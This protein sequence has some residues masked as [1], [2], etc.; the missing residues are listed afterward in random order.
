MNWIREHK[1]RIIFTVAII[2]LVAMM[3]FSLMN[4]GKVPGI[5]KVTQAAT[6]A[7]ETP[8]ATA[9]TEVS[10]FFY[11]LTHFRSIQKE[12]Y[13]LKNEIG[14]LQ[15]E[16]NNAK[17]TS[18][19]YEEFKNIANQLN[20]S[21]YDDA[22]NKVTADVIA[23]DDS[24]FFNIFTINAGS[25]DG[26]AVNNIVINSDGLVGRVISV[27]SNWSKVIGI[28]DSS[29]SISF[30]LLRDPT[31]MGIVTGDGNGAVS[32]YI[33][34]DNKSILEGDK[35]LTSGIGLYP[36]GIE[37]GKVIKVKLNPSTEEKTVDVDASVDFTSLKVVTVL[38]G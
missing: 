9:G 10:S 16:L 2:S 11:G 34:D 21:D 37:I 3:L 14:S 12:N 17:L 26:I 8:V 31:V 38:V 36:S 4:P 22:F 27:G 19:Q 35:L 1:G 24:Q 5:F 18:A 28:V 29:H 15:Q 32:G 25:K 33:F 23:M 30:I 7:I 6:T 13:N 20:Y